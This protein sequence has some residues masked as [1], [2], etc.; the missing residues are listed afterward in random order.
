MYNHLTQL[1]L[2]DTFHSE[3]PLEVDMLIGSELY[4]NLVT[5]ETIRGQCGPMAISTKLGWVLSGPAE[6]VEG[7]KPTVSLTTQTIQVNT[8][9]DEEPGAVLRSFWE[10][11]SWPPRTR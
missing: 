6:T 4:W 11:V 2:A 3:V 7:D 5:S 10:L 1:D 9:G 8:L